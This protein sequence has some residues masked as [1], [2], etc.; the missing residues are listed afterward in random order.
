L[1]AVAVVTTTAAVVEAAP[2]NAGGRYHATVQRTEFGIPHVTAADFGGL[3]Y[4]YGYAFAQDNLCALQDQVLTVSGLRS[5]HHGPAA[6]AGDSLN[7]A[8]TNLDSDTFYSYLNNTGTVERLLA[9][10]A[11][12][13]PGAD[14]RALVS[15]YA[16]GVNRYLAEVTPAGVSD[17]M[18]RG[19]AWLRSVTD[20]DIYRIVY[21]ITQVGG[22]DGFKPLIANA[23]PAAG[24]KV[25]LPEVRQPDYGSNGIAAGDA[26]TR[27]LG[28]LVVA[29][30][31]FPW[32]GRTRF[33]QAHLRIPG[34]IDVNGASLY[35]TPI[36]EIGHNR[37]LAWTH[38]VSTAQRYTLAELKLVPGDPNS[39]IVDGHAEKM[40]KINTVVT[41]RGQDGTLTT[42]ERPVHSS[43]Y[44]P[45][46]AGTWTSTTAMSVRG[47]SVTNLRAL[48]TW[49]AMGRAGSVSELRAAQQRYQGI[50]FVNTI[51]ADHERSYYAD[52]SV[53]PN[54]TDA[55]AKRC[56]RSAAG[57]AVYP[58]QTILD[59][60]D[61]SCDWERDGDAIESGIFGPAEYPALT[62]SDVVTNSN[63]SPWLAN[64]AQP[65]A[66][67]Q[68]IFGDT[69]SVRSL[70]TRLG[71]SI[72]DGRERGTD[73]LGAPG[74]DL[75]SA[76]AALLSERNHSAELGRDAVV[77]LCQQNPSLTATDHTSVDVHTACTVLAAWDLRATT[78][79][80]AATLW[81]E[82]W[83]RAATATDLWTVPFDK[84]RPAE[85]P[86]G[87]NTASPAVRTALADAVQ[88]MRQLGLPLDQPLAGTQRAAIPATGL[89]VPGCTG[90]EGCYNV[91]SAGADRGLT[92]QGRFPAVA[93][94]S[95]FLMVAQLGPNAPKV[96]TLT[97]YSQ[98]AN[99]VS[100]HYDDQT[101]LFSRGELADSRYTN[102]QITSD[103]A[104]TTI[105][106]SGS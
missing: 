1:T 87:L 72:I 63:D 17:P 22:I 20:L 2:V 75:S 65:L 83:L 34:T 45:V 36:V 13:G 40:T 60:S 106:I 53:V 11:P 62:R 38:T 56:V 73:G 15:G 43:R 79:S 8:V 91:V 67:Y 70:R 89:P 90:T 37:G 32:A 4:G 48:D 64:P 58:R 98:S 69:G 54:V 61:S 41:V 6:L 84:A 51:A 101:K 102:A 85:T 14:V 97:T 77:A 96:R 16:A 18:C 88:R 55:L 94:G 50:P 31:H 5:R 74:F 71:L 93:F 30:P 24:T 27:G 104:L 35:G 86:N 66:D 52:A 99:P 29:N 44:G 19:A 39:Y 105:I 46:L 80:P 26:A 95:S 28:G 49:L 3:G 7:P 47:A 103:P 12:L 81:R 68:R 9:Q 42:V 57:K 10:R 25:K 21:G 92:D 100:P 59:G 82:F 33:Y 76:A 78:S 23:A